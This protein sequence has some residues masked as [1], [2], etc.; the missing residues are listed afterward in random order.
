MRRSVIICVVLGV[1]S[2]LGGFRVGHDSAAVA[3][4]TTATAPLT[5]LPSSVSPGQSAPTLVPAGTGDAGAPTTRGA[6]P[7]NDFPTSPTS[8]SAGARDASAG[9]FPSLDTNF[10]V[11]AGAIFVSPA[12]SDT[13]AG[14]QTEPL[15]TIKAGIARVPSG[16]T[17]VVRAGTYREDWDTIGKKITVQP[18]PGEKVSVKGSVVVD[19]FQ[20]QGNG[21]AIVNFTSP[22][23]QNCVPT[24]ALNP[25]FAM[26]ANP[27]Q[28]FFDGVPQKQVAA[29]GQLAPG[30]FFVD[31]KSKQV[32]LGSNPGQQVVEVAQRWKL[33]EFVPGSEGSV[34]R[35]LTIAHYAPHWGVSDG[36]GFRHDQLG[37]VVVY[38]RNLTFSHNVFMRNSGTPL[39]IAQVDA[40][41][42]NNLFTQNGYR[43]FGANLADR[44]TLQ[45]NTF[46]HSNTDRWAVENCAAACTT[47]AVK[48]TRATDIAVD[49]NKFTDTVGPGFWCDLG[50][51]NASLTN[52][53]FTNNTSGIFYE[54]SSGAAI[55]GNTF[56]GNKYGIHI[57]GSD[58][59][60]IESNTFNPN[61]LQI[62]L[63]D[64]SRPASFDAH[65]AGLQL[66]WNTTNTAIK[67][68]RFTNTG[69]TN[70]FLHTDKSAG[71][72]VNA[73]SFFSQISGN[74]L[75]G[76]QNIWWCPSGECRFYQTLPA[77]A[78][79]T[80]FSVGTVR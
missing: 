50:C 15:R 8:A 25:N 80:G 5:A 14:T 74:V 45:D 77:F 36:A 39:F 48:V 41:V 16:G 17:V 18:F 54:V 33:A 63:H 59:V 69:N 7:T 46:S 44:L 65:A 3:P 9:D 38:A 27:D 76:K 68:N 10:A 22:F 40:T 6:Q 20:A 23:C 35:G 29:A 34:I 52:N 21:W 47:A 30:S 79:A 53:A 60:S 61:W 13:A 1:V 19:R 24:D 37:A 26:A 66:S 55:K 62:T 56:T 43:A 75:T 71:A 73:E 42:K 67:N 4:V 70:I 58:H 57:S 64:D 78:A 72:Q 49:G 11:P 51:V 12:G 31:P 28:V 2:L 32:V